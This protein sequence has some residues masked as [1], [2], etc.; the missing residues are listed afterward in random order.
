MYAVG[1]MSGTSLDGVDSVL[2]DIEGSGISTKI[3]VIG[4]NTY[5][6]PQEIK[7]EIKQACSLDKSSSRLICS[8][9]FKIGYLFSECVKNICSD[10]EFD[11]NNLDFIASHGQTIYHIPEDDNDAVKSTLQIGESSVIAYETKT[12][13]ISNFRVMDMA[14]GGE[15]APLVPF[16]EY[17]LYS[18]KNE[19][20]LLQN[21]G[22]I[23]NVTVIPRNSSIDD[24]Y[25]FDTGPGNMIIDE[26]M[27]KLFGKRYDSNGNV[28]AS[29]VV[30]DKMLL[31]LMS[32]PYIQLKPPKT[33]GR[34][35]FGEQYVR[36]LLHKYGDLNKEDII[37]TVTMF[38]A[39]SIAENYRNFVLNRHKIDKI[40]L[41]GGGAHNSTLVKFLKEL[42]PEV[43]VLTQEEV[44]YSSDAKE[45]IAFVVLGNETMHRSFSNVPSAT[46]A[47]E[48]V[49][50]G[51]ICE[52]PFINE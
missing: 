22:G 28:A 9:N 6:I 19:G 15:G 10:C 48:K 47:K 32:E 51:T 41:G 50:L 52:S 2:V 14:A 44:G 45:A 34:E 29:G 35:K 46:G 36:E 1:L 26:V 5:E 38:T 37:A 40:I 23:G 24:I 11:I 33:T 13:V 8:L 42:L 12:K 16:S 4:F 17:I 21:I 31:D 27:F 25:A 7:K 39:K 3:N 18:N 30:I 43:S 49:I 20:V